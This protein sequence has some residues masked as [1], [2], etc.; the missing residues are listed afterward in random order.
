MQIYSEDGE[1]VEMC[2]LNIGIHHKTLYLINTLCKAF[3]FQTQVKS[4]VSQNCQV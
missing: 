1:L 4:L 3:I 2:T